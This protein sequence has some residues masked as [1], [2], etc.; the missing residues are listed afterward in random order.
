MLHQYPSL[1]TLTP[2]Q[3]HRASRTNLVVVTLHSQQ[4][5]D[6]ESLLPRPLIVGV[7][8][9]AVAGLAV[10]GL[11]VAGLVVAGLAVVDLAVADLVLEIAYPCCCLGLGRLFELTLRGLLIIYV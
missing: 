11:A 8:G 6:P 10:A 3:E 9:L 7:A 5:L 4:H 1:H 2:H